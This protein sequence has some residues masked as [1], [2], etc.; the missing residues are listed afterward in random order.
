MVSL[1]AKQVETLIEALEEIEPKLKLLIN[2]I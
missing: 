1:T 2:V